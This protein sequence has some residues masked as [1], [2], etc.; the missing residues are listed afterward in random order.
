MKYLF[1]LVLLL[2]GGGSIIAQS[3]IFDE[4]SVRQPGKGTVTIH[5]SATIRSLV[6]RRSF[7]EKIETVGD[8]SFLVM[9][10]YRVQV[11]SGNNQRTSMNEAQ[12]KKKQIEAIF[13]DI[14]AYVNFAAP[15][16]RL[17]V[18]DYV[19]YEEAFSMMSKL[20][21]AFPAFK[22]EIQI[23]EEEIRIPLN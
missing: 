14:T 7:D 21:V 16:W 15:F 13:S 4:L 10:G 20:V 8:K 9:P 3:S 19:S 22:R 2:C 6:G 1:L 17:H 11:F 23:K 18:G 12:D 5:Q